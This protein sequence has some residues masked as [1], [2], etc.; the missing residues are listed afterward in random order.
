VN[1]LLS[2]G[3][4]ILAVAAFQAAASSFFHATSNRQASPIWHWALLPICLL[5]AGTSLSAQQ[6]APPPSAQA[7][8]P[9]AAPTPPPSPFAGSA[10]CSACH[11]DIFNAFQKS[12][13]SQVDTDKHRGFVGRVCESCHGPAQKH[14]ESA[15]AADIRQP[16][17][18]TAAA[19]DKIC[20]SC[21]LNTPTQVGRLQNSHAKN[22]VACT[23]CH[24]IHADGPMGL[25]PHGAA[26]INTECASC[27]LNVWAQFQKPNHHKVPENAMSCVDC[28]N[29]H[30]SIR[31]AMQQSFAANEPGCLNCHGDKRGPF[32]FEHAPV[33][34]EGCGACH[35]AHGSTN[36][37][38]LTRQEVRFVCLECHANLP[39][40]N[41]TGRVVGVVPPAFHDLNSPRYQNC[42]VCHQKIHGSH[43]D[44]NLLK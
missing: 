7:A 22:Q 6:A 12:P 20:M 37:R 21:H 33:R 10:A 15:S 44:R 29:P 25:V 40:N 35:E 27:H 30:G 19:A 42:T 41:S 4:P 18:M 38:L 3:Q 34:F 13:H 5:L 23:T 36:P 9:V 39:G 32:A 1:A 28:H 16:A 14:T 43:I 17:K 24:K 31:P 11:E 2:V 8:A 26:A